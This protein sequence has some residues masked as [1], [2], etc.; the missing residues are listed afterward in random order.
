[1]PCEFYK[2]LEGKNATSFNVHDE[3]LLILMRLRLGLL[4]KTLQVASIYR[5]QNPHLFLQLG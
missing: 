2:E 3:F 1:M 4:M 5:S